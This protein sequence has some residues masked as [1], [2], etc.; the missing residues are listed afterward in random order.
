MTMSPPRF[1]LRFVQQ[2]FGIPEG[3][4]TFADER[5]RTDLHEF[6]GAPGAP[7]RNFVNINAPK[8]AAFFLNDKRK[9]TD[10]DDM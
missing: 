5:S 1:F 4:L 3:H 9:K 10:P 7:P 6:F 2:N 8:N